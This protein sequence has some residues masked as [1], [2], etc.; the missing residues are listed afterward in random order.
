MVAVDGEEKAA[1]E[2]EPRVLEIIGRLEELSEALL[3][4]E[5]FKKL[6]A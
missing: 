3:Q 2:A 1:D 4:E 5:E 6:F